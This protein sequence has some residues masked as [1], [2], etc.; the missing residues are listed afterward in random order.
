MGQTDYRAEETAPC[1]TLSGRLDALLS[2][3]GTPPDS[4]RV[5]VVQCSAEHSVLLQSKAHGAQFSGTS[6]AIWFLNHFQKRL[7]D[8]VT[9]LPCKWIIN[10]QAL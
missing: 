8:I 6:C 5:Q 4:R 9:S 3:I 1:S 2:G 7:V 10:L